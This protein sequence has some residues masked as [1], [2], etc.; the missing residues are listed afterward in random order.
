MRVSILPNAGEDFY[1]IGPM[2]LRWGHTVCSLDNGPDVVLVF[3]ESTRDSL[4][5]AEVGS[6]RVVLVDKE[7]DSDSIPHGWE[8]CRKDG[9]MQHLEGI[10]G[11][12]GRGE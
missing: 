5:K 2:L 9:L 11:L 3:R 7:P 1:L 12:L 10:L 8:S 6:R 4:P